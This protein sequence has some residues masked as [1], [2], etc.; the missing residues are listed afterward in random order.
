MAEMCG[1]TLAV[2]DEERTTCCIGAYEDTL[3]C[4]FPCAGANGETLDCSLTCIGASE[5][6]LDYSSPGKLAW[7][8]A[9]PCIPGLIYVAT[10]NGY[11]ASGPD[12]AKGGQEDV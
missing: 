5:E 8:F 9:Q 6:N 1:K 2:L 12:K 3:D 10:I 7:Y 4:C 11:V